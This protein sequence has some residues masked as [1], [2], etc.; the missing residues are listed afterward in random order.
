MK[1]ELVGSKGLWVAK[2]KYVIQSWI[3]D[4]VIREEPKL[5]STGIDIVRSSTPQVIRDKLKDIVEEL[6]FF[7]KK[8]LLESVI[9]YRK[10]F[11]LLAVE[12]IA[13]PRGIN[14]IDKYMNKRKS[15]E[16]KLKTRNLL[17]GD[18]TDDDDLYIKG[19]PIHV[20]G[21]I[22]YN[23]FLKKKKLI[24]K[25]E[26]IHSGSKIRF[27]YLITPNPISENVIAFI[28]E[29]PEEFGLNKYIDRM[30]QF[31]KTF[32]QPIE[33]LTKASG[34]SIIDE[35]GQSRSKKRRKG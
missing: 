31:S 22:L 21:A 4:G 9:D 24:N 23:Y 28:D 29:L 35:L 7:S 1:M 17:T 33:I 25:Y 5:R 12:Q 27:V 3:D 11:D 18:Y 20:R 32:L 14:Y 6:L 34:W 19:T 2:K 30:T 15:V 26:L 16:K 8:K 13:F 10:E